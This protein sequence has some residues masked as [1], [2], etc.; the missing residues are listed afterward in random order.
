MQLTSPDLAH[1]TTDYLVDAVH[2]HA[3]LIITFAFVSWHTVPPF[4]F[5]GRTKKLAQ[6]LTAYATDEQP[7]N[8]IL[9]RDRT[10]CWYLNGV[11]GLGHNVD[12]TIA[13]LRQRITMMQPSQI[14]CIGESMGGYAAILYGI[15]LGA[16]R[17]IS[18]G[19]LS[20]FDPFFAE[21]HH[22]HRWI[23]IMQQIDAQQTVPRAYLDLPS[24]ANAQHFQGQL[25]LILGMSAGEDAPNDIN[26]D[27]IHAERLTQLPYVYRYEFPEAQHAVTHWLN[28][29]QQLDDMLYTTA[30][31]MLP[32][33]PHRQL[34][35]LI[36]KPPT[37]TTSGETTIYV[38]ADNLQEYGL[39]N[40]DIH[41]LC[42][43]FQMIYGQSTTHPI[44][45][46]C[47][48]DLT[49]HQM[50]HNDSSNTNNH[51]ILLNPS[52]ALTQHYLPILQHRAP[53]Y[54]LTVLYG[55]KPE[56]TTSSDAGS[57]YAQ[58]AHYWQTHA[59]AVI[60]PYPHIGAELVQWLHQ[61]HQ[62]ATTILRDGTLNSAAHQDV[63]HHRVD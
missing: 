57:V 9:L 58:I 63:N 22:D 8:R 13:E 30:F 17:I 21:Q 59:N 3:P 26:L 49:A 45:L 54:Q 16:D 43:T 10:N 38:L 5:F 28:Q 29:H 12:E 36:A 34:E 20:T 6:R 4:Y 52:W 47:I 14:I 25:H 33:R 37:A 46:D 55:S 31:A 40:H 27:M 11:N 48:T 61:R 41:V 7:L 24:L 53:S 32:T 2:L 39:T 50:M 42:H 15:L 23:G 18:A 60:R 56:H 1:A 51:L 35:C 62:L 44:T 19:P